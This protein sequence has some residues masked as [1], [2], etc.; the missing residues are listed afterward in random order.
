MERGKL[1]MLGAIVCYFYFAFLVETE[2]TSFSSFRILITGG[3]S[4]LVETITDAV[5]IHSIK[6]AEYARRLAEGQ[7]G[8]VSL[9]DH[10]KNVCL[11]CMIPVSADIL[12]DLWGSLF[13]KVRTC[14][15]KLRKITRRI[16]HHNLSSPDQRPPQRQHPA[17][18][19]W[20]F[21]PHRFW[22]HAL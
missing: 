21:D 16:F 8:H 15:A 14:P 10:F 9:L 11:Y 13:C 6:K 2:L 5:S 12:S 1:P 7:L 22:I 19:R 3:S 17:G 18:P 4:G 20:P